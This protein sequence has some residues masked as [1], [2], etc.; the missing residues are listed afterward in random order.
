MLL[1]YKLIR[2]SSVHL[3]RGC[4]ESE[5]MTKIYGFYEECKWKITQANKIMG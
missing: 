4:D 3:L 5:K 1:L 2:P